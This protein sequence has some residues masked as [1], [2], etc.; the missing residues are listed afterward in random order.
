M[1]RISLSRLRRRRSLVGVSG[2]HNHPLIK[3]VSRAAAKS[4]TYCRVQ[5]LE[6]KCVQMEH[7]EFQRRCN[8]PDSTS[9]YN[10][11]IPEMHSCGFTPEIGHEQVHTC[12]TQT[13]VV[14]I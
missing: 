12:S 6:A 10:R 2:R 9:A 5:Y 3:R 14:M 11:S 13:F 4:L 8:R 1:R 7:G